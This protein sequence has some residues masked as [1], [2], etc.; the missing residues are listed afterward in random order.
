MKFRLWLACCGFSI[1][2]FGAASPA[3]SAD[4]GALYKTH[5]AACHGENRFGGI[6][7][8]LLPEN[9][10]RLRKPEALKVIL[11]GRVATQ[12][13]GFGDRLNA[14]A[15]DVLRDESFR[16]RDAALEIRVKPK[17]VRMLALG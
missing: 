14:E 3:L 16:I 8:A 11:E 7:P 4:V 2:L 9:L 13:P 17:T 10:A 5:C 15:T 1:G 12:M 6:G